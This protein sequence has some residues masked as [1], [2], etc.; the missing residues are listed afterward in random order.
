M[1][2][3][4]YL[5]LT[6]RRREQRPLRVLFVGASLAGVTKIFQRKDEP[7]TTQH[8]FGCKSALKLLKSEQ[9][10]YVMLDLRQPTANDALHV[11]SIAALGTIPNLAVLV[12]PEDVKKY[13]SLPGIDEVLKAPVDPKNII[14]SIVRATEELSFQTTVPEAKA[15]KTEETPSVDR[16]AD[17]SDA[18]GGDIELQVESTIEVLEATELTASTI[19]A[20]NDNGPVN[21]A[22]Q[23]SLRLA[24]QA[25]QGIWQQFVPL[26]NF[27]YKKTAITILT[28][29][30]LT[31]LFYGVMIVFF[32]VS[33]SWSLPFELSRGHILVARAERDLSQMHVRKN[34]ISQ[35][36]TVA[37]ADLSNAKRTRRDAELI[38]SISRRT[39]N[40]EIVEQTAIKHEIDAH[41]TRLKQVIAD[42]NYV[43]KS[44]GFA[45]DLNSAYARRLI[46]KK[47]LHAGTLAVLE[48]MHRIATVS[49]EVAVKTIERDR[50]IRRLEFLKSLRGELDQPEIR[51]LVS[52]GS[53]L[54][55]LARE[56]IE[57]KN[58]IAVSN[59]S[60][61]TVETQLANLNDSLTRLTSTIISLE[62]TPIGR[63][64]KAPV[65]V[66][67]VPYTNLENF[68]TGDPLFQCY[69]PI[70][71]CSEAGK[72]GKTIDGESTATHPLFGKPLRGVFV[73]AVVDDART[74]KEEMLHAGRPPLFF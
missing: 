12:Q 60:I 29:L 34:Q 17:D 54:V 15:N 31:F 10:D 74:I 46:T 24:Q 71:F 69:F 43:N 32:M 70:L 42:F 8:E 6:E 11:V 52:A 66:L 57:S 9:F 68:K 19:S 56:V 48:T 37:A 7:I 20:K 55:H 1:S 25:D 13:N 38:L 58:K 39:I 67:F 14:R 18:N 22:F 45:T 28:G 41:I 44:D 50:V 63:A 5:A 36:L 27:F 33:S 26:A 23:S 3:S 2:S 59:K 16:V 53:D 47:S 40:Q 73:E 64:I 62:E 4:P 65:S 35:S 21:K 72:I 51:T 49:N 61:E 30:F